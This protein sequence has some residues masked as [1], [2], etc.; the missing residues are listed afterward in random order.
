M[1]SRQAITPCQSFDLCVDQRCGRCFDPYLGSHVGCGQM[2]S[3]DCDES[4]PRE[5]RPVQCTQDNFSAVS[6]TTRESPLKWKSATL[7]FA[8]YSMTQ[9]VFKP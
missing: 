2:S 6:C 7:S 3:Y 9:S 8:Y 5:C 4:L 1:S